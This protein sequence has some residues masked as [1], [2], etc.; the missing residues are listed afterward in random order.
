MVGAA[1]NYEFQIAGMLAPGGTREHP[2][3]SCKDLFRCYPGLETDYYWIDPNEASVMD[4]FR[5]YC[6]KE[7]LETCIPPVTGATPNA[8]WYLGESGHNYFSE[9]SGGSQ[10]SYEAHASQFTFLRLL[11]DVAHQKLTYFCKNSVAV[12][13]GA[14]AF[15]EKALRLMTMSGHELSLEGDSSER[16]NVLEDGCQYHTNEWS[17]TVIEFTTESTKR[18]PIVDVAP[19]DIGMEHQQFG[20]ELGPVCFS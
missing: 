14:E 1:T 16:Y 8:T 2:A 7:T 19:A 17:K 4:A 6:V 3:R 12:A 18:L 10:F 20:L 11:S 13:E 15:T 9:M 5:V